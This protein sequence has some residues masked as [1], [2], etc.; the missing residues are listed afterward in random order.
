V[1]AQ[2]GATCLPSHFVRAQSCWSQMKLM[3]KLGAG[4]SLRLAAP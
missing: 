1:S 2:L 3:K 4:N